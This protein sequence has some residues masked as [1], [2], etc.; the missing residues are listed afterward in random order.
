MPASVQVRVEADY[1]VYFTTDT[2]ATVVA[3]LDTINKA[4]DKL[5]DL[6]VE[7]PTLEERF[8]EITRPDGQTGEAA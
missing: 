2:G 8:L 5:V 4:G 7:R 1:A 6:R 3:V